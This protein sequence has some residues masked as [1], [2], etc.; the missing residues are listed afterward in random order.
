MTL[1]V[2]LSQLQD[3]REEV[4]IPIILMGYLNP[5][6]QFGFKDFCKRCH[7]IGIDGL[8]I[9]DLPIFEYQSSYKD[10]FEKYDLK[11][12]FLITPQTPDDRIMKI[13]SLS[14]SFIY[15]VSS[16][17][18][19]G[20]KAKISTDQTDYFDRINRMQ[21]KNPKLIGFGISNHETYEEACKYAN[22]AIVGSAFIKTLD[23]ARDLDTEIANFV[24]VVRG[25]Q[26]S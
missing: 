2:L 5:I 21:L 22:G 19:T 3:I 6:L 17:S 14:D 10:L 20:A 8:I 12:I 15:V 1:N 7:E 23:S 9:P 18:I 26:I 4:N 13:D 24:E 25:R 16:S 11:N